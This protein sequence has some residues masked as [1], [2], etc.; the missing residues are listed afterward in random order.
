[1]R[2][3]PL[4]FLSL[5]LLFAQEAKTTGTVAPNLVEFKIPL[6][7]PASATWNWNRTETPDNG[8]EYVWQVAVPNGSGRYSFGF[9]LYKLPGSK[10]ARG[11]L[12]A[13]FKAGQG[14]V[15]KEDDRG[16]VDLLQNAKV[17]VS[18]EDGRIVFRI[19]DAE[20]IRTIFGNRPE[21]VTINTRAIRANFEVVTVQYRK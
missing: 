19:A 9:Y 10:P 13:L 15:F 18:A 6:E 5:V 2:A 20:L 8:G 14:S 17:N 4:G 11:P 7:Q 3:I 16:R 21:T 12:Q 1:M